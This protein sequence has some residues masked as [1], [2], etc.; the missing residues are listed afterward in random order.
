MIRLA[1]KDVP[2]MSMQIRLGRPVGGSRK[3]PVRRLPLPPVRK[4]ASA[5]AISLAV[6]AVITPPFDSMTYRRSVLA[7]NRS[8]ELA[9][10]RLKVT[11]HHRERGNCPSRLSTC[12]RIPAIREKPGATWP[13][14]TPGRRSEMYARGHTVRA[15]GFL[16]AKTGMQLRS[17]RS[18][19]SRAAST[20]RSR[21]A[22]TRRGS[23]TSPVAE[24]RSRCSVCVF[25][26]GQAAAGLFQRIEK[27]S[28][29]SLPWIV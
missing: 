3:R 5:T 23:T 6:P 26:R 29:R 24:I 9:D 11:A 10:Q 19:C 1:S 12:G 18:G 21:S 22:V 7:G 20:R 17:P 15:S 28:P 16:K 14:A 13:T 8:F 2:P 4:A 25:K 27:I